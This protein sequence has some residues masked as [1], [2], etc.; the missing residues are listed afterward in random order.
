MRGKEGRGSTRWV[1]LPDVVHGFDSAGW[2]NSIL[3]RNEVSRMDAE[4]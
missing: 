4:M 1:L 3:Y 2:R